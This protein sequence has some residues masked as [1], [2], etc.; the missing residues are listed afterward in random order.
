MS[1]KI[2]ILIACSLILNI[3]LIGLVMGNVSHR[4]FEGDSLKRK[5]PELSLKLS[6]EKEQ[7]FLDTMRKVRQENRDTH[8]Q[9][10]E[11]REKIFAILVAPEFNENAY[12]SEVKKLHEMRGLMMQQYSN[13]T[14]ELA[15][16]FSQEERE[17]LAEYLKDAARSRRSISKDNR[18]H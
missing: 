5:Q 10:K 6:S 14:K 9:M 8:V 18:T 12:E 1:K 17:A 16:Q 7:L 2:K 4:F 3:L 13:A 15:K 11:I